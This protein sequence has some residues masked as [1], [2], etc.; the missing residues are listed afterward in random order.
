MHA[1][2]FFREDVDRKDGKL[3]KLINENP[4]GIITIYLTLQPFNLSTT[5]ELQGTEGTRPDHSCCKTLRDIYLDKLQGKGV[6]LCVKPTHL[7]NLD[8]VKGEDAG[9]DTDY[10][11]HDIVRDELQ[12]NDG[13]CDND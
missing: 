8:E 1:E 5:I 7:C 3:A 9:D 12:K 6:K 13:T 2:E 10:V 11:T 4:E